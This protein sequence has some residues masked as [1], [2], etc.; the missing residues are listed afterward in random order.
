MDDFPSNSY[1]KIKKSP[2]TVEESAEPK[3]EVEKV[4]EGTVVRRKKPLSKRFKETFLGGDSENVWQYVLMDVL[5]PAA[6]DAIVD[7]TSQGI[8]RM[9]FGDVRSRGGRS[10]RGSSSYTPYNRYSSNIR[11]EE[12]RSISA[13]GRAVH[14]FDEVVLPTRPE[15]EDVIERMYD[16]V[17]KYE[18][19]SVADLY[20]LLGI[21]PNYTDQKWGWTDLRGLG[22]TRVK[23][24]YLI[25][26]PRPEPLD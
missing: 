15:A 17:S 12:P 7:A 25:D 21:K 8:E 26:V 16:I 13:R 3:P 20:T 22:A 6:K 14:N 10:S 5:I 4:V 18:V 2:E 19:V 23:G 9:I 11:K 1:N 24:G